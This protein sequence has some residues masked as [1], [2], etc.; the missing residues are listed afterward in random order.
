MDLQEWETLRSEYL[1]RQTQYNEFKELVHQRL[2][3]AVKETGISCEIESRVKAV[4]SFMKK[5]LKKK[6][7]SPLSDIKDQIGLRVITTYKSDLDKIDEIICGKFKICKR[8]DK[9][10]SLEYNQLGYLGIHFEV[11]LLEMRN[12]SKSW[13]DEVVCEIQ[14]HT[15]AQSLWSS[16]SHQLVYKPTSPLP[17]DIQRSI[18]RLVALIE[19]FDKEV[20]NAQD[21]FLSQSNFPEAKLLHSLEKYFRSFSSRRFDTDFSIQNLSNLKNLLKEEEIDDFGN[22]IEAFVER[23]KQKLSDIFNNYS[24]DKRD[25]FGMLILFQPESLLIFERLDRDRFKLHNLW[26]TILP[27]ELLDF[28]ATVWGVTLPSS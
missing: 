24:E 9:L 25:S 3:I 15:R 6:Y 7:Q 1:S 14:L 18:Y 17:I 21:I 23:H 2:E 19:I 13:Y 28:M 11:S 26:K 4:D 20:S 12:Q 22:L 16:I 10:H 5:A 27:L 8:E